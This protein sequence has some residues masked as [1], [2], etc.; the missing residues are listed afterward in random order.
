MIWLY[1]SSH[2]FGF[3]VSSLQNVLNNEV[4]RTL[5]QTNIL[6]NETVQQRRSLE[7]AMAAIEAKVERA[8]LKLLQLEQPVGFSRDQYEVVHNPGAN[9]PP[10]VHT[11]L[12]LSFQVRNER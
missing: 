9:V 4:Q 1:L 6:R 10:M 7:E 2:S 11:E 8:R 5:D 3:I 12:V